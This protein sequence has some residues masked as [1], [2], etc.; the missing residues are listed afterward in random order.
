MVVKKKEISFEEAL[1]KLEEISIK[2]GDTG[3]S[4]EESIKMF[5]EGMELSSF[6]NKK[7]EEAE[8]KIN[9]VLNNQEGKLVEA[10]FNSME[11]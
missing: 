9:I 1:K 4:L 7:L 2:M 5:Q 8:K 3:L 6:C 10:D 11:E